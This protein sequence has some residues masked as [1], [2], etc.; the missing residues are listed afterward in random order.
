MH[1]LDYLLY[2]AYSYS[3]TASI[4]T[5]GYVLNHYKWVCSELIALS[6]FKITLLMILI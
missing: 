1:S 4:N 2:D 3:V 5:N 6:E